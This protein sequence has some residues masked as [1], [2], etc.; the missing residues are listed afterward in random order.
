MTGSFEYQVDSSCTIGG[1]GTADSFFKM[2]SAR[3]QTATG[4]TTF[5]EAA[6]EFK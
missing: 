2:R 3:D 4:Y 5:L 1:S 6:F